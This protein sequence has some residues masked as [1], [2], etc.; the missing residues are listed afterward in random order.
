MSAAFN[1]A[2]TCRDWSQ[3]IRGHPPSRPAVC[4]SLVYAGF[5]STI[6]HITRLSTLTTFTLARGF[7][8]SMHVR[9]RQRPCPVDMCLSL[10]YY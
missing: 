2:Q 7:R 9:R 10:V 6:S 1:R 4:Y 5:Q 8:V 3:S